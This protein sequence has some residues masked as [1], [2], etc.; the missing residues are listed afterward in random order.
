MRNANHT[1]LRRR[2]LA[3]KFDGLRSLFVQNG[4]APVSIKSLG[5]ALA[6]VAAQWLQGRF[7]RSLLL[8][9]LLHGGLVR[10]RCRRR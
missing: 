10:R 2:T 8:L 6:A 4:E 1:P 9:I 3:R 5:D 7:C